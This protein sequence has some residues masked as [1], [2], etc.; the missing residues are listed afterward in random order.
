VFVLIPPFW[1]MFDQH[2]STWILQ[3]KDMVPFKLTDKYSIG[4][5]EMQSL[6]PLLVMILVPLLTGVF[7]P[8]FGKLVTPLRRIGVGMFI[9]GASY[10]AVAWLQQRIVAGE[11]LSVL[12]QALPYLILTSAE[13]LVSTTGLEFAYTQAAKS[14]KSTIM[15]LWLLTV[16]AGNLLVV[17]I[18]RFGGGHAAGDAS[19]TP[20][21]FMLYALMTFG[22]S[23][24]F[25]FVAMFYR[26][27]DTPEAVKNET[28]LSPT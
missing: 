19:V 18:T 1:A 26:Y 5:E 15:S 2:S 16:A 14:M 8:L 25:V 13:V 21:R 20:G 24:V 4:G 28:K 11:K 27:R 9:A 3:A 6:N 12:W 17:L 23:A 7:Y 22:V 10:V